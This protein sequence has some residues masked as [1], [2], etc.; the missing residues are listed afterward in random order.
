M[1]N[2][3]DITPASPTDAPLTIALWQ[4]CALTRPWNDPQADFDRALAGDTSTIL[5]ARDQGTVIGSVM[6]GHDGH[7]GWVYYLAVD[8]ARQRQGLGKALMEATEQWLRAQGCP[9]LQLMVRNSNE[10]ALGFYQALGYE[11]QDVTT[12]GKW[13]SERA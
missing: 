3:I 6:I 4:A 10:A 13:L 9:K 7:R 8:P 2:L 5:L 1:R 12:L 11:A